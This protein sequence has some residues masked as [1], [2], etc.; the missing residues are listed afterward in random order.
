MEFLFFS[1]KRL[2]TV[3]FRIQVFNMGICDKFFCFLSVKKKL[4]YL[5]KKE[6]I[7]IFS[8]YKGE[9]NYIETFELFDRY[10]K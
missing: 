10:H 5:V 8:R 2:C 7:V 6:T 3:K 4:Q 1:Y 9:P